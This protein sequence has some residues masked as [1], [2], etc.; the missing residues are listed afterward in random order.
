MNEQRISAIRARL[1]AALNPVDLEIIDESHLHAGHAGAK[2]GKGHF[3]III[4]SDRFLGLP[5]LQRHRLIYEAL[6]DLMDTDIH[7]LG[8]EAVALGKD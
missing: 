2:D 1:S 8:I 7:A 5:R 6:R 3:R 4:T